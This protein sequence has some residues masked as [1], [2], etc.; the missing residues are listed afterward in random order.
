[1]PKLKLIDGKTCPTAFQQALDTIEVAGSWDWNIP[2]DLVR[3]DTFVALLFNVD[4]GEAS[5][6]LP[7]SAYID[8]IHRDDREHVHALIRRCIDEDSPFVAEYRVLSAD[9]VTRWVLDRGHIIR[10]ATGRPVRGRGVIVDI[11]RSR[12]G[13]FTSTEDAPD[14]F[15]PPL[16]RAA[17]LIIDAQK[18]IIESQDPA[19]K[20]HIDVLLLALGRKIAQQ[21]VYER[22]KHMN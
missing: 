5:V 8:G 18:L 15:V 9:G 20:A 21:E 10:D 17:D 6:G 3:A 7:L 11:T 12:T 14:L 1:M 16:E 2:S 19:L 13:R 4:P 22:R